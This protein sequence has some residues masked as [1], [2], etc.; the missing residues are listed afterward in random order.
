MVIDFDLAASR[1]YGT[2]HAIARVELGLNNLRMDVRAVPSPANPDDLSVETTITNTGNEP[3][4]LTLTSFASGYPRAKASVNELEPGADVVRKFHYPGGRAKL[5]GCAASSS[6]S[7]TPKPRPTSTSP[8]RSRTDS[9]RLI[10]A[11]W[12]P[13][14][15][16]PRPKSP[17]SSRRKNAI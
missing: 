16:P 10:A 4:T 6:G 3:V 17:G 7:P 9:T 1:S 15:R 11:W 5:K 13:A 14:M 8:S 12:T 2:V